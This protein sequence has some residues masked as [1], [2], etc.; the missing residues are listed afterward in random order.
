[1]AHFF[2]DHQKLFTDHLLPTPALCNIF[3][4]LSAQERKETR[5]WV[6]AGIDLKILISTN[7]Y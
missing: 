3:K 4:N 6:R 7:A 2:T 1:M 5:L